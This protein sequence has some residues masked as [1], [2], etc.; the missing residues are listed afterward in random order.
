MRRYVHNNGTLAAVT[1]GNSEKLLGS[2]ETLASVLFEPVSLLL[3]VTQ[4]TTVLFRIRFECALKTYIRLDEY[5]GT[6]HSIESFCVR[7]PLMLD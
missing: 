7:H 5:S 3:E 2:S 1:D 4:L 6:L